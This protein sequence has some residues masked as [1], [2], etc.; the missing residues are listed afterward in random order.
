[1]L[2]ELQ[3]VGDAIRTVQVDITLLL[4]D[5]SFVALGFEELPGTDEVLHYRDIRTGLD[6]KIAGIEES[7]DIQPGDKFEGVVFGVGS[8]TLAMQVEV[9][10]LGS[11]QVALLE[12]FAM[13]GAIA[14][15]DVHMVHV[16]R[17]PYIG[18]CIGDLIVDMSIDEEI[19]GLRITVLDEIDT[20]G[21]HLREVELHVIIFIIGSPHLYLALEGLLRRAVGFDTHERG[22]GQH[23]VVLVKL[24]H[25]HLRLLGDIADL[26]ETDIWLANPIGN[27]MRLYRPGDNLASLTLWQHAAQHEPAILSQHTPIVKFQFGIITTDANH[28]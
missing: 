1:M 28:T 20:R 14:L 5:E 27:G 19:V 15:S 4:A 9:I 2:D 6:V 26:R 3:D 22:G 18:G 16:D 21:I 13:P 17:Y 10:A 23:A 24:D 7:A 8:G 12:G 11:L 25:S